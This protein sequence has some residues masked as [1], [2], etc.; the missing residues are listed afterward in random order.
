MGIKSFARKTIQDVV[1]WSTTNPPK[2]NGANLFFPLYSGASTF[3]DYDAI[4]A[5][6]EIPELAAVVATKARMFSKMN[7]E[8]VS[9]ATGKPYPN[10]P[11]LVKILREPNYF[12]AQKEFL[13]Q[14]KTFR[15][16]TG[17]EI[18]YMQRPFGMS[19]LSTKQ[20]FTLP[21]NLVTKKT[22]DDRPFFFYEKPEIEYWFRWGNQKYPLPQEMII[23]FSDNRLDMRKE[24]W[25]EGESWVRSVVAPLNNIK[26]AYES[27]GVII[28]R[29][30]AL[31]ILSDSTT[32]VAG[33]YPMTKEQKEELQEEYRNYGLLRDQW[34][35][36]I[37]NKK[38]SW[39]QMAVDPD[40]LGLYQEV[41][42]DF[43]KI[44][45]A[46]G[47]DVDMFGQ[48]KGATFENKKHGERKT[49]ESTIIPEAQE[50]ID[51]LNSSFETADKSWHIV[52][53][54]DLA[55]LQENL[56]ERGQAITLITGGLS[57]AYTDGAISLEQYQAELRKMKIGDD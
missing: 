37:S 25:V 22:T 32:D 7:L 5:Y 42:E 17:E 10:Y 55:V 47:V 16:L 1:R 38:L 36:I 23:H 20:M 21:P 29:R 13:R 18:L 4:K 26:A 6:T 35:L 31:G 52:G 43:M 14:T 15:E 28:E 33:A 24:N 2:R 48:D 30:G 41:R 27:R 54:F 40:K 9:K 46:A 44:C 56:K 19:M 50:W 49:Y 11:N 57:K 51:G 39:V 45:D 12:Q 8:A 34:Q 3:N 53:T